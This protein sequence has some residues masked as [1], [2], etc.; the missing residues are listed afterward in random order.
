M[1][2]VLAALLY[3]YISGGA[4]Y[5]STWGEAR[6]RS[7][8]LKQMERENAQLRA[9]RVALSKSATV[10]ALARRLGMVR[11]GERTYIVTG[12]PSN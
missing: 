2:C 7:A 4:R 6:G 8:Q 3:L 9:E 11:P 12:L 5:L 1:L 10:Q